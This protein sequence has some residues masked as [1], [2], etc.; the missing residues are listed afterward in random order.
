MKKSILPLIAC[1]LVASAHAQISKGD[2][3]LGGS[4][5]INYNQSSPN[6]GSGSNTNIQPSFKFAYKTN[7]TIGFSFDMNYWSQKSDDGKSEN[8]QFSLAPMLNFTQYYPI[9]GNFGWWLN[10][11]VGMSFSNSKSL[12]NGTES[13]SKG[14]SVFA[15][16]DPGLYYMVGANKQW[17]LHGSVGG[18]GGYYRDANGSTSWGINMRLFTYYQFGFAYVF[19]K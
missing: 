9:K 14:T 11:G 5:G 19:K 3:L 2:K 15:T 1:L 12:S 17:M 13:K 18:I 16:V 4:F 10:E 7:R 6:T 8:N